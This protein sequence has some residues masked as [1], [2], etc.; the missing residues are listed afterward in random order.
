MI[1]VNGISD[2]QREKFRALEDS[3]EEKSPV[4]YAVIIVYSNNK[5]RFYQGHD[6]VEI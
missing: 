6:F 2:C 4:M 5:H 3:P 1:A